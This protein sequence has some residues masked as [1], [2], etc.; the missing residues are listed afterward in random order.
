MCGHDY[1][2]S[3]QLISCLL[4]TSAPETWVTLVSSTIEM[5]RT[6]DSTRSSTAVLMTCSVR[7]E[8]GCEN[9]KGKIFKK[10]ALVI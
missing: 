10:G 9:V 3:A 5:K 8:T 6:V 2:E 1:K 7:T 4:Y